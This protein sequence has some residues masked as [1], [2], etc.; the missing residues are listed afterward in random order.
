MQHLKIRWS[1]LPT[2]ASL[3]L[4][5][6]G[7]CS[8]SS[9]SSGSGASGGSAVLT[10][11]DFPD[12]SNQDANAPTN[13]PSN[14]SLVQQI[15]LEFSKAPDPSRVGAA[16]LPVRRGLDQKRIDA[17][18]R[19][20]GTRVVI[21]PQLP[22]RPSE[23]IG[24]VLDSGG[25]GL[26]PGMTYFLRV[27]SQTWDFVAGVTADLSSRFGDPSDPNG[28][29][30]S[31]STTTDPNRYFTGLP[32]VRP[33]IVNTIPMDGAT[34]ISP[35]LYGDPAALFP[36]S[37]SFQ[38]EFLAPVRADLAN[39]SDQV[40]RII[41][42]DD[43]GL[44][45]GADVEILVNEVRRSLVRIK[46]SGILPLG[47]QLTLEI[48]KFLQGL[49]ETADP[50]TQSQVVATFTVAAEPGTPTIEDFLEEDF[51]SV[52]RQTANLAE[53]E[54]G[55]IPAAWDVDDSEILQA[56]VAVEGGGLLGQFTPAAPPAGETKTQI[57]DTNSQNFPLL[58]GSTPGA[59]PNTTIVGG[60]FAF[61]DINIPQGIR[62]RPIGNNPLVLFA[63]GTVR[64]AGIIDAGGGVG[65]GENAYDSAV[66][67][68][69]GGIGGAGAG[70]GGE[71]H[72]IL[73]FPPTKPQLRNQVPPPKAGDGWGPGNF[74]R[75][76]GQGGICCT[77]DNQDGQGLYGTDTEISCSEVTDR[78]N[79]KHNGFAKGYKP[80]GGTGGSFLSSGKR[81]PRAG[82]GNVFTD[83][84]GNYLVNPD[85][86][87][88]EPGS[89]GL[90][91][92]S[93][94]DPFNNFIG[95]AGELQ[96]VIAGQGGGAGGSAFDSYYC[97]FWCS[98]DSDPS[99][100][101]ICL[102]QEFPQNRFA[103]TVGDS[104]GGSA[105]GGGGAVV[106]RAL[107]A[108]TL[109]STSRIQCQGG[110]GG[111]GEAIACSN[112]A[113]AAGSGSGGAIVVQSGQ[114]ITVKNGSLLN[115]V[116]G[117]WRHASKGTRYLDCQTNGSRDPEV[118]PHRGDGGAGGDGIIQLQV[119]FGLT[120]SVANPSS[121]LLPRTSWV[122]PNNTFNP[123]EFTP[124]SVALS[125]WYDMGRM[126]DR[127]PAGTNPVF[128]FLV[129]GVPRSDGD[130]T[131]IPTDGSGGVLNP[132]GT[133][134][135][136]D[137]LGQIDPTTGQFLPGEEPRSDYI[138]TNAEIHV[139]FQGANAMA[140]GSK[141]VDAATL[142]AWS[143]SPEIANGL[144][145]LRYRITFD[146]TADGSA[147]AAD[148]RLPTVQN[149]KVRARF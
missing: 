114:S 13:P 110:R 131:T 81:S 29:V 30:L 56:R 5:V 15:V 134:I 149:I 86:D 77:Y 94:S 41:D 143:A 118:T 21:T 79:N 105:G 4:L 103:G 54:L 50:G 112:W 90:S 32:A 93:D 141:E 88:V 3:T 148:V 96:E 39:V 119:P 14:A 55:R 108:V 139:E 67:S 102:S 99:N 142:T 24:G 144:Q 73:F 136:C 23:T 113:G 53:I 10:A 61:T 65:I 49:S 84:L 44:V 19:V 128:E 48:P 58:D 92:F 74:E 107:G 38:V 2:A 115:V 16:T 22:T 18:Y 126:I 35:N 132:A 17:T 97:G 20:E 68:I 28:I 95:F 75:I 109:E 129:E 25:A 47:H 123:S 60:V 72:P 46:P 64:I 70:R 133:D 9:G 80:P 26:D 130:P 100:D 145:F 63:T 66:A 106:I 104:R 62:L 37:G 138:P 78:H 42:L 85:T 146:V 122:D 52:E 89:P 91:P 117:T 98:R 7:G 43:G 71:S 127:P 124:L 1:V 11:V 8:G 137:Y 12:P 40:F 125:A 59:P 57:L 111:G 135:Q 33:Q 121:S 51:D 120:A 45:L 6:F 76:G 27:G 101:N 83:G 34:G 140:P 31:F 69:P 147:L 116:G 82:L 87:K 36:P